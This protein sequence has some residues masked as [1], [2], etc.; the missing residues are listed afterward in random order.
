MLPELV[1]S[2]AQGEIADIYAQ[3]RST[4]AVPY[5]SSLQRHL[6]TRPGWLEWA[7][8]AVAPAFRSGMGPSAAWKA[9]DALT[10][11][12]LPPLSRNVLG[13]WGVDENAVRH[14]RNICATFVRVSPTNLMFSALVRH[15]LL[16]APSD[17]QR[18][19]VPHWDAPAALPGLPPLVDPS[20]MGKDAVGALMQLG[21]EVDGQPF[22]PGIYRMLAQWPGYLA[23]VSA[24]LRPHFDDPVTKACCA[25]LLR[26]VDD[27]AAGVAKNLPPPP[28]AVIRPP[29]EQHASVL[30]AIEQ[31]RQTSPQM[32]VFGTMLA[33][34]LPDA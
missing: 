15:Q 12:E 4:C 8:A 16:V 10:V 23:H 9:A 7:W 26:F 30:D 1:E 3:I 20:S 32:V 34:A 18:D 2:K 14:I 11:P 13:V 33:D 17:E 5:V 27:A 22:V 21:N 28:S 24:V 6:A 25:E 19:E 29:D 31:Y